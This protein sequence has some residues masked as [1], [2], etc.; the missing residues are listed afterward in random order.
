M[1]SG[2]NIKEF[3]KDF[4]KQLLSRVQELE[5]SSEELE[6]YKK[7]LKRYSKREFRESSLE[8]LLNTALNSQII[9]LG[10]FHTFD[11]NTKNLRRLISAME[12]DPTP[13]IMAFEFIHYKK[14]RTID[15]Y[16]D[17]HLTELEFLEEIDFQN[18][19]RFPWNHYR[20]F[21]ELAREKGHTIIGLN[22]SGSLMERDVMASKIISKYH[23]DYPDFKMIVLFGELH[24]VPNKLP[25]MVQKELPESKQLIIHQNLDHPYWE[26]NGEISEIIQFT[27]REFSLQTS[28]PWIK[29]ESMIYWYENLC[30]DPDYDL[31]EIEIQKG[32]RLFN[33]N[34]IDN[35][36]GLCK[37]MNQSLDLQIDLEDISHFELLDYNGLE[38]VQNE[39]EDLKTKKETDFYTFLVKSSHAFKLPEKYKYFC[40]NYSINR[41]ASLVGLHLKSILSTKKAL[42][43]ENKYDYF[44]DLVLQS[45]CSF[46]VSKMINHYRKCNHYLDL[47][48]ELETVGGTKKK[49]IEITLNLID[50]MTSIKQLQ[51]VIDSFTLKTLYRPS[52]NLGK[53]IGE[54]T[55][56]FYVEKE[57]DQDAVLAK[58]LLFSETNQDVLSTLL[59][60]INFFDNY[61]AFSKRLF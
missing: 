52:R 23:K 39:I 25:M 42:S 24:I 28:P 7:N 35:F 45:A 3:Q 10:D 59:E 34:V 19:W 12:E 33:S 31:H 30:E 4:Y 9:Y 13:F 17:G 26:S 2:Q 20:P 27:P 54:L 41:L 58:I 5:E 14:Q 61:K 6:S 48:K 11:Q 57:K 18:S 15:Y 29:Y 47:R 1:S 38:Q 40:P 21:F 51:K 56:N 8:K 32:L 46:F 37:K 49:E 36:L 16:L 43:I 55:F 53:I 50:H 60:Q 44:L 22:T